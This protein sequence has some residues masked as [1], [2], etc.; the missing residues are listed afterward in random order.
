MATKQGP[1]VEN[2][3]LTFTKLLS[4]NSENIQALLGE[5]FGFILLGQQQKA[6]NNL[7][8]L[9]ILFTFLFRIIAKIP[10]DLD[11]AVDFEKSWLLLAGIYI[12]VCL[13]NYLLHIERP[14][15]LISPLN[16]AKSV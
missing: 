9:C 1:V 14:R 5:A 8:Y 3:I 13:L 16:Y 12:D 11:K 2:A 6:R 10:F 4:S 15:S 7:K